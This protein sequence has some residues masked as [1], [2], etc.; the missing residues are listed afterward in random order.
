MKTG[1]R[2]AFMIYD[3]FRIT[4]TDESIAAFS[5]LMGVSLQGDNVQ[6]FDSKWD[7]V[8]LPRWCSGNFFS[9]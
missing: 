7:E 3:Y 2:S 6:G 8:H 4:G 1:R 9:K 5:D